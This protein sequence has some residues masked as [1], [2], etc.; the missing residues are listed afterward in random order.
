MLDSLLSNHQ[1]RIAWLIGL[2]TG[3]IA[4]TFQVIGFDLSYYP[5]DLGDGRLN[6]YFLEHGF[7]YI[8][9]NVKSYWNAPFMYP[10]PNV[11]AYSDNLLGTLPFYAAFRFMGMELFTAY[12][13]WYIL[14]SALNY[15]CA[16]L[17][18]QH[19]FKNPWAAALGAFV[20]AFSLSMFSQMSHAQT[21][22]RFPIPL[23]FLMALKYSETI[24]VKYFIYALLILVYQIYCGIYLGFLLAIPLGIFLFIALLRNTI[25]NAESIL[26]VK[27]LVG[28]VSGCAL[29]L[30]TLFPLLYPYTQRK[31]DPDPS[32]YQSILH[33]IPEIQSYLISHPGTLFWNFLSNKPNGMEAWW[34]HQLFVGFIAL[35]CMAITPL[36]LA[37]QFAQQSQNREKIIA[38]VMLIATGLITGLIFLKFNQHTL[39]TWIYYLPGFSAM[40]SLT[41]IIN[42][43]IL[44]F[45]LSVSYITTQLLKKKVKTNLFT[46]SI[47]LLILVCDNYVSA[48]SIQREK[49]TSAEKRT[50]AIAPHFKKIP[51][52]SVVSYEPDSMDAPIYAYQID[53][54][55]LSQQF[56]MRTINAYTATS[57]TEFSMFWKSPNAT[58][59]NYWLSKNDID[60]DT[61]Y[62]IRSA[63]KLERIA[64]EEFR[65][66]NPAAEERR[67]IEIQ[68][69]IMRKDEKWIQSIEAKAKEKGISLDSMLYLDA[70]WLL[71]QDKP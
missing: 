64:A 8:C 34:D 46:F 31:I 11:I 55:L 21:F 17:L 49:I 15:G 36:V 2:L 3:M 1:S 10:E 47:L 20:F 38:T 53:A 26:N 58:S 6:L 61:L 63:E 48:D 5:G 51:I 29:A 33:S 41:R 4:F 65:N 44:F 39:Y 18:F 37:Y 68:M 23:A 13:T 56:G 25:Q 42:I 30:L 52:N 69:N 66:F 45:A 43:E 67:L 62:V 60:F 14:L 32:H 35:I 27:H 22:A 16:F 57:P 28:L 24:K 7:Q 54:M 50:L 9:G 71:E 70:K 59:R 19:L 12:Q 40:R